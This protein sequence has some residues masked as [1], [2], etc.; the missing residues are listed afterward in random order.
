MSAVLTSD[1]KKTLEEI[2]NLNSQDIEI[3][4][5]NYND[6]SQIIVSGNKDD[7]EYIKLNLNQLVQ[8][9]LCL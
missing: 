1:L 5:S 6:A 2:N 9:E 8:K 3:W 7:L 4:I